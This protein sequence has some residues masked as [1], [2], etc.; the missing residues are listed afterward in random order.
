M[1]TNND[2]DYDFWGI[3]PPEDKTTDISSED[4][5]DNS[6]GLQ[7]VSAQEILRQ[8]EEERGYPFTAVERKKHLSDI[9]AGTFDLKEPAIDY[10]FWGVTPPGAE[11]ANDSP[12][13]SVILPKASIE[14]PSI[15]GF[16]QQIA[17][18][19]GA[20]IRGGRGTMQGSAG[21]AMRLSV[22][23][24]NP[25]ED[26]LG[27]LAKAPG[28][29]LGILEGMSN[30]QGLAERLLQ[31][32]DVNQATK[33][34]VNERGRSIASGGD[35]IVA[36][37]QR[38]RKEQ[39]IGEGFDGGARGIALDVMANPDMALTQA[40]A[41]IPL[42]HAQVAARGLAYLPASRV[43]VDEYYK[44]VDEGV[45]AEEASVRA[46]SM[47][48]IELAAESIPGAK[49]G[50][51]AKAAVTSTGRKIAV[52]AA[53]E[54]G[55]EAGTEL[56]QGGLDTFIAEMEVGSTALQR[57][58]EKGDF[59]SAMDAAKRAAYAG[60]VGSVAAGT[61]R[62]I[63]APIE[64]RQEVEAQSGKVVD[65]G[66]NKYFTVQEQKAQREEAERVE[67]E[68]LAQEQAAVKRQELEAEAAKYTVAKQDAENKRAKK[69]KESP[70]VI[71]PV[72]VE[73][74][75][76]ERKQAEE[77]AA[78]KAEQ[79]RVAKLATELKRRKAAVQ[80]EDKKAADAQVKKDKEALTKHK[81]SLQKQAVREN[82]LATPEQLVKIYEQK[83]AAQPTPPVSRQGRKGRRTRAATPV[84][85]VVAPT[86][87]PSP[88]ASP[89]ATAA[90]VARTKAEQG[91]I[92]TVIEGLGLKKPGTKAMASETPAK[93]QTPETRRF[94][95]KT[96]AIV[97]GIVKR[98]TNP[99][100]DVQELVT[101]GKINFAPNAEAIGRKNVS[102][103]GKD[104]GQFDEDGTM[105]L[106]TDHIDANNP[107]SA[108]MVALH[109]A[110]HTGQ[111]NKRKGRGSV[112][113]TLM[114]TEARGKAAQK[115]RAA[116]KA[117][118]KVA[119]AA[120]R[121]AAATG[122]DE[123]L[124]L[125]PYFV[126]EAT[127]ARQGL[128]QA[129]GIWRD[130]K[131][132]VRGTVRDK[133]GLD[134]DITL[135]EIDAA[136]QKVAG[137]IVKT[138]VKKGASSPLAMIAGERG[139]KFAEADFNY[140]GVVDGKLRYEF[141][142]ED[143]S[144]RNF[145]D[146]LSEDEIARGETVRLEK[147]LDHPELYENYP[148]LRDLPIFINNKL[149]GTAVKGTFYNLKKG[150]AI[151]PDILYLGSELLSTVLHEVQH[152]VQNI[153][154]FVPGSNNKY[155][156][157]PR[158][159]KAV[160]SAEARYEDNLKSFEYGAALN[161]LP[162]HIKAKWAEYTKRPKPEGWNTESDQVAF[163]RGPFADEVTDRTIKNQISDYRKVDA[164]RKEAK[165]ALRKAESEAFKLYLRDYGE[166]E[167]RNTEYRRRMTKAERDAERPESTMVKAKG[168][169]P[170][171]DTVDT[172]T[173]AKAGS[174]QF[175]G[176][177]SEDAPATHEIVNVSTGKVVAS[178][179]SLAEALEK[180]EELGGGTKVWA[181]KIKAPSGALAMAAEDQTSTSAFK[182]W[183]KGSKVVDKNG[184]PKVV[185]HGTGGDVD[186]FDLNQAGSN[187]DSGWLGK[188]IY[189]TDNAIV[190][191]YYS[192]V[193]G[194]KSGKGSNVMPLFASMQNPYKWGKKT[195]GI[196][197]LI[198][199]K[200]DA[201]PKELA[202]AV[203]DRAGVTI[204]PNAEPDFSL[205][206][207]LSA[208]LTAELIS[209]G[210]DG[211]V[212]E[213]GLTADQPA[214]EYVVF[215]P[216]QVKSAIGNNGQFDGN[217]KSTVAMAA[218]SKPLARRVPVWV[219]RILSSSGGIGRKA[220]EITE[221][222]KTS[223]ATERM[224]AEA[225]YDE[226]Q[227]GVH[228]LAAE[229]GST[230]E[231]VVKEITD[232]LDKIDNQTDGREENMKAFIDV[233]NKYGRAG[234][235]LIKFRMQTDRLTEEIL[236]DRFAEGTPLTEGERDTFQTMLNN[237]GR[238]SHRQYAIHM[239]K[240]GE[241]F[242]A[243][244]LKDY[245]KYKKANG[246]V[247]DNVR[248]NYER[249]A[250]AVRYLVDNQLMIP[251][252]AG[253][254][255]MD[256]KQTLGMFREWANVSNPATM[257]T[258]QQKDE[259]ARIRDAVNGDTNTLEATAESIVKQILAAG[260]PDSLIAQSFRPGRINKG[261][262]K[263]RSAIPEEI[264]DL[265][266]EIKD[267]DVRMFATVAKQAE[268][269]ARQRMLLELRDNAGPDHV[270]PPGASGR[271]EVK[272]MSRLDG[273]TYGALQGWFVS[274]QLKVELQDYI[275]LLAT[276]DQAAA[277]LASRP[278]VLEQYGLNKAARAWS[279][280]VG[281]TKMAQIIYKPVNF[282][283]NAAGGGLT[284]LING[285]IDPRTLS[286][287][288]RTAIGVIAYARSPG[289][290][291]NNVRR[292]TAAGVTDS[293]FIGEITGE[294]NKE[295]GKT[296][297]T[298]QGD[299]PTSAFIQW[300]KDINMTFKETYAMMDVTYKIA[301]FYHQADSVLPAYY[302]AAGIEKTQ[303]E[304]DR[305]AADIVNDTNVT[306]KRA[307]P[308][309]K[310]LE[311]AGL[312]N[313]GVFFYE[314]FR[315]QI[316]NVR[317]G[318]KELERAQN[319]PNE[320]AASIMRKQGAKRITGQLVAWSFLATMSRFLASA[321]FGDEDED[322]NGKDDRKLA[323]VIGD[324][325]LG[326]T[327]Q[328]KAQRAQ[329]APF[330]QG[331]D[332]YPVGTDK[333]GN[334]VY[335]DVSRVDPIGP[336][337]DIMRGVLNGELD[338]ETVK[339]NIFRLYVAPRVGVQLVRALGLGEEKRPAKPMLQQWFPEAY[340]EFL[341]VADKAP[342]L[343]DNRTK[344]LTNVLET[345]YPGVTAGYKDTNV[346]PVMEDSLSATAAI[347]TYGG[348]TM[349]KLD[350]N[351]LLTSAAYDYK[352]VVSDNRGKIKDVFTDHPNATAE[353][354]V[355][356]LSDMQ[357]EEREAY[358]SVQKVYKSMI[359]T[360]TPQR[361]V[362]VRLKDMGLSAKQIKAMREGEFEFT[363]VSRNSIDEIRRKEIKAAKTAEEKARVKEKWN[364]AWQLL[365]ISRDE[366][367]EE[368]E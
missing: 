48:G 17:T 3:T 201:M 73:T 59:D 100:V 351:R 90:P 126:S 151:S 290:A 316:N 136:T 251:D 194:R 295:I 329:M 70:A 335:F 124:E 165:D 96:R 7:D 58:A 219:S 319:A 245:A 119:Q 99:D 43:Y 200:K 157:D 311:K 121:K 38:Y 28:A 49:I 209:R 317:Q 15:G 6:Q 141:S 110:T 103:N 254:A 315:S 348:G 84:A 296:L 286:K 104:V 352:D 302:E 164:R 183:F 242:A 39:G 358:D 102:P 180:V 206:R 289:S 359:A 216:E 140:K 190:A 263:E 79:A 355:S 174:E 155:L 80:A 34:M 328:E 168:N 109:E 199:G 249:V 62:A 2:I 67:Q 236:R 271:P 63:S 116:A 86:A 362:N 13:R 71:G 163:L 314:V 118:N 280:V 325:T 12:A 41:S 264:R 143:A 238:Y 357:D 366:I 292:V 212:A 313:F 308:I 353:E 123:T 76:A 262:L 258:E 368:E 220:R 117:G 221:F 205:E 78:A 161:S 44:L 339:D 112:M 243:R 1:P 92:D 111:E 18:D 204:D 101:Q 273:D 259:L 167:A 135:D 287:A 343:D 340:S 270:Q 98:N 330:A 338:A 128:G 61:M 363:S 27:P 218:E 365:R 214:L 21:R 19:I 252:D 248:K 310:G 57:E 332:F 14:E 267:P 234:E 279:Q 154:G 244:I 321:A 9:E 40:V 145:D 144:M 33:D 10:D 122:E 32:R 5:I 132:A 367:S 239:G 89:A 307:A 196:R 324:M 303:E 47:A 149:S 334:K 211:V 197:G 198:N 305:E 75:Q 125:V 207:K 97:R 16:L 297:K 281:Y 29:Y 260:D 337:S 24:Q 255:D 261:I 146:Y 277:M 304:I 184:Q 294:I 202:Q 336:M 266:G 228:E 172:R 173:V 347:L 312:T 346:R 195:Q 247:P 83:L 94:V 91:S 213:T 159:K 265:M 108:V 225:T 82:P 322:K 344:A 233:A 229:R 222:A 269:I 162:P 129:G 256:A 178:A 68:R 133:T 364:T 23:E 284:M 138:D 285:N 46:L 20:G 300:A 22:D 232:A 170:V 342:G 152:A 227:R 30:P 36:E 179:T 131:A 26:A 341:N 203:L 93:T 241:K 193:A 107:A 237:M 215:S 306:Y 166:A 186:S 274:P 320:E 50:K 52:D 182:N 25:A 37:I 11:P 105:W 177:A 113:E 278:S 268:F 171:E 134:I 139:G 106:F 318:I 69:A 72:S 188:G 257:T 361:T 224:L 291:D 240:G 223:P 8:I 208:A 148:Q 175:I 95:E 137:E 114:D 147:V 88:A 85:P 288:I 181:R 74:M 158:V 326:A 35:A 51:A 169:I 298:M 309:V 282:L 42:P 54:A 275:Q 176:S 153:E 293:A 55:Q 53:K 4:P 60:T 156:L 301:N 45:P 350:G 360:G 231:D 354:V 87:T 185:Y 189:L 283:F 331:Q 217:K 120:V 66:L 142:D 31:G 235:A 115:I 272:G 226:Y 127:K 250:R 345:A 56:V 192:D 150:I 333:D 356:R 246:D 81:V 349:F 327:E 65:A 230:A 276:F 323:E 64:T 253:L 299:K 130:I 77:A 191:D 187:I 210:H 160:D